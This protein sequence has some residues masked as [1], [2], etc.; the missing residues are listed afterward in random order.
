MVDLSF[1]RRARVEKISPD[2]RGLSKL[3][4]KKALRDDWGFK[5][6]TP[7]DY[8]PEGFDG[9]RGLNLVPLSEVP[10]N[11][12]YTGRVVGRVGQRKDQMFASF[13]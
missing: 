2:A 9:P 1:S 6:A 10:D 7:V 8:R 3:I 4:L 5:D 13:K 12:T 11:A